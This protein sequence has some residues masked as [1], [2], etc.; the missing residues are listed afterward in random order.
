MLPCGLSARRQSNQRHK[1]W[2]DFC[3]KIHKAL[4]NRYEDTTSPLSILHLLIEAEDWFVAEQ[5]CQDRRVTDNAQRIAELFDAGVS[6]SEIARLLGVS[7]Q[8]V[9]RLKSPSSTQKEADLPID[10]GLAA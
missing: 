7:R 1:N 2:W 9:Y 10:T 6:A 8:Y 4:D 3:R 5:A